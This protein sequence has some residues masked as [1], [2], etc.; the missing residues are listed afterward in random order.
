MRG[1][2]DDKVLN[3][4]AEIFIQC[5]QKD[6]EQNMKRSKYTYETPEKLTGAKLSTVNTTFKNNFRFVEQEL[7]CA[8]NVPLKTNANTF[9]R[10]PELNGLRL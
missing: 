8:M 2:N 6:V 3:T 9:L 10:H 5:S 4:Y 1:R 7:S